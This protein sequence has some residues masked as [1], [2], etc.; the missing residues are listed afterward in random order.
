M[1]DIGTQTTASPA[2]AIRLPPGVAVPTA[3][4]RENPIDGLYP[5][6]EAND[7]PCCRIAPAALL[8]APKPAG[9]QTLD[10]TVFVPDVPFFRNNPQDVTVSIDGAR[11]RP[12]MLLSRRAPTPSRFR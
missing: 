10:L 6:R 8:N 1:S 2:G 12:P 5:A 11:V 7:R 9:A 4:L 3:R